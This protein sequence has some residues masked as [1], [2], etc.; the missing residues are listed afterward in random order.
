MEIFDEK[1]LLKEVSKTW[2]SHGGHAEVL[3]QLIAKLGT[4]TK[5][6]DRLRGLADGKEEYIA[7]LA[8]RAEAAEAERD[9]LREAL[10][11]RDALL[12]DWWRRGRTR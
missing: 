4:E 5:R 1:W 7:V 6:A 2:G 12:G 9:R 3:Q 11:R 8:G 10:E